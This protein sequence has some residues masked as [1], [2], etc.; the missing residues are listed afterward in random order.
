M[1]YGIC[2]PQKLMSSLYLDWVTFTRVS[3]V[4]FAGKSDSCDYKALFRSM[5]FAQG[6][7]AM[8]SMSSHRVC[9][10][11]SRCSAHWM[12]AIH[13]E[14]R[15]PW[16]TLWDRDFVGIEISFPTSGKFLHGSFCQ[17]AFSNTCCGASP[18]L[19]LFPCLKTFLPPVEHP[20]PTLI[21]MDECSATWAHP[22]TSEGLYEVR[23]AGQ[24]PL[25]QFFFVVVLSKNF[26]VNI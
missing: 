14:L 17:L 22:M 10:L 24:C 26:Y 5:F 8:L 6:G 1:E 9:V 2:Y 13:W 18:P 12:N 25:G 16:L 7:K 20:E 19:S 11:G 4:K 23:F 15:E 21:C 3:N